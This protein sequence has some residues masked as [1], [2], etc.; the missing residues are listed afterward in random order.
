MSQHYETIVCETAAEFLH[1]LRRSNRLW[2]NES[3]WFSTWV[4]RGQSNAD[5]SLTPS[6]WR[7]PIKS[8]EYFRSILQA[9]EE[10]VIDRVMRENHNLLPEV[11]YDRDRVKMQI[12]Q[13][14]F[15]FSQA[16]AFVTLADELGMTLPGGF[17]PNYVSD[18]F[19]RMDLFSEPPHPAFALAQHHG[20]PTRLLDWTSNPLNAAFFA[21]ASPDDREGQIAVWAL[22]TYA[23]AMLGQS[24]KEFRV[25]RSHIGFLHSQAGLFTHHITADIE[26]VL[27]GKWPVLEEATTP[28]FL[29]KLTLLSSEALELRR[30]LFVEGVSKA[31]LMP[32]LDNVKETLQ[33]HWKDILPEQDTMS[34]CKSLGDD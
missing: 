32:T 25:P 15:E 24:W 23:L 33:S 30:L 20:M 21:A 19:M 4:F 26:F 29:K 28:K 14:H 22:D 16:R 9:V 11:E 2:T 5:W 18:K 17:M 7:E 8:S 10:S 31:H 3:N 6:A 1:N 34:Y 13:R 12:A 27:N